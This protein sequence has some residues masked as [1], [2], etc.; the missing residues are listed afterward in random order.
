MCDSFS[1]CYRISEG[2]WR[3]SKRSKLSSAAWAFDVVLNS[4]LQEILRQRIIEIYDIASV[5]SQ[6]CALFRQF[7]KFSMDTKFGD[8]IVH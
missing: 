1:Q 3:A 7:E 2:F 8:S 4:R 6:F 5:F